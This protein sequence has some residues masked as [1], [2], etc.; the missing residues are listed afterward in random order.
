MQAVVARHPG[1]SAASVLL[2]WSLQMGLVPLITSQ[3]PAHQ[4]RART[5][6]S[7]SVHQVSPSVHR[8]PP[9]LSKTE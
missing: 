3:N 4:V 6:A 8:C 1:S 5:P 2:G 9:A 7:S